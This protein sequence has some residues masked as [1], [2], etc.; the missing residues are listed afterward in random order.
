M[1]E[2]KRRDSRL[3]SMIGWVIF[4]LVVAGG[5]LLRLVQGA[6]GGSV[7]LTQYLPYI[8]GA[9]LLLSFAA[10]AMRAMSGRR[11]G[12]QAST[13][14]ERVGP[15]PTMQ[16]RAE[17]PAVQ[18]MPPFAGD[19]GAPVLPPPPIYPP[20]PAPGPSDAAPPIKTPQFD[21]LFSPAVLALGVLGLLALCG[22]ALVV[23][24][25]SLP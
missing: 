14:P 10:S 15:A 11:P 13:L 20:Q 23:F 22:V 12:G 18:P 21:P 5:P 17:Q 24:G 7:Q 19:T 6:L 1:S 16:G 4:L 25:V 2:R 9:L 3:S 8:I